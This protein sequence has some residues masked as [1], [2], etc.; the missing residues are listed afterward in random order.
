ME[1]ALL[2]GAC[3]RLHRRAVPGGHLW[4]A[5]TQRQRGN[6]GHPARPGAESAGTLADAEGGAARGHD[7][8]WGAVGRGGR[9]LRVTRDRRAHRH[10]GS[11]DQWRPLRPGGGAAEHAA[12]RARPLAAEW[13]GGVESGSG[14]G[15]G[16]RWPWGTGPFAAAS[17]GTPA[18][19]I[20]ALAAGLPTARGRQWTPADYAER[21]A[22]LASLGLR[23][24]K[25]SP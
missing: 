15:D 6:P 10:P 19:L 24:F 9:R 11:R 3:Q 5:A 16:G 4:R 22:R 20:V 14:N 13:A 1:L 25:R 12:R 21:D 18:Q 23:P 2:C 7:A 17:A 8:A